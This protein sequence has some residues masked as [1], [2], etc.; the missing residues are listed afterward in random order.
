LDAAI[1]ST[2]VT[3]LADVATV[4]APDLR[5]FGNS[6]LTVPEVLTM[7]LFAED[8]K[9]LLDERRIERV[10]LCG[11]SM[12]GY[13]AMSFAEQWPERVQ[14]LVLC[15]TRSTAD[16]RSG[17]EAR[18][19]T[20]RNAFEKGVSVIARGMVPKLVSART[21]AERPELTTTL[22][23]VIARQRPEAV[24]AASLGMAQRPDRTTVLRHL[25]VPALVITGSEDE[26]MP[27]PT[28]I[29]MEEAI[30]NGRL[31]VIPGAAHLSNVEASEVFNGIMREFLLELVDA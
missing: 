14:G 12:G 27:L 5:G 4:L 2:Q 18:R 7:E 31:I 24:A 10:V 21:Q 25:K 17:L 19:Q 6:K 3:A 26:L 8:M 29:L 30:P 13:V 9:D 22:G 1:W 15:N 16:D 23:A 20:A 11:L 28:S